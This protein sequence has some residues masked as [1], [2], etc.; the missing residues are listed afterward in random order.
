MP[1]LQH[2]YYIRQPDDDEA[3]GPFTLAQLASLADTGGLDS[4]TLYFE[5][6]SEQWI[7][8]VE[9]DEL[10]ILLRGARKRKV[11]QTGMS[12]QGGDSRDNSSADGGAGAE[13]GTGRNACASLEAKVVR[14]FLFASAAV[15]FL[16]A[17]LPLQSSD[18]IYALILYLQ[19]F[20]W[21]GVVDVLLGAFAGVLMRRFAWVI[22]LRAALGLGFLGVLFWLVGPVYGVALAVIASVCLWLATILGSRRALLINAIAGLAALAGLA[23]CVI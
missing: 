19:P 15:F 8:M 10:G 6:G 9:A 17:I 14:V 5:A 7:P 1:D 18:G 11:A 4:S 21:L 3:R 23:Y 13:G 2:E 16:A 22:R 20:F 12:V